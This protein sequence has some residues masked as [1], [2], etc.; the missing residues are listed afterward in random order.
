MLENVD[1]RYSYWSSK[2]YR[3]PVLHGIL[4]NGTPACNKWYEERIIKLLLVVLGQIT[5]F[6][7]V[8]G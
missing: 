1:I 7:C 5:Y 6:M 4:Y 8:D 2:G 3:T